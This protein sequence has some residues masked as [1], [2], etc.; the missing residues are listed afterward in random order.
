MDAPPEYPR[1]VIWSK[2]D[3]ACDQDADPFVHPSG[4]DDG[5]HGGGCGGGGCHSNRLPK[6]AK[7]YETAKTT[8][9]AMAAAPASHGAFDS[10][11]RR[12]LRTRRRGWWAADIP[13][14]ASSGSRGRLKRVRGSREGKRMANAKVVRER[15]RRRGP[16]TS[17]LGMSAEQESGGAGGLELNFC[18]QPRAYGREPRFGLAGCTCFRW[19]IGIG[20][21]RCARTSERREKKA[22]APYSIIFWA[23]V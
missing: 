20:C 4:G 16:R 21:A 10:T 6:L 7:S 18:A 14:Y 5:G 19:S 1:A 3:L 8:A 13:A 11:Y 12:N 22:R 15:E 23:K 2:G 9:A 17:N